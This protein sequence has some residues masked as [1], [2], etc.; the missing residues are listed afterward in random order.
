MMCII[1]FQKKLYY[2]LFPNSLSYFFPF[3]LPWEIIY[4]L[5]ELSVHIFSLQIKCPNIT[6]KYLNWRT[7]DVNFMNLFKYM[8][9]HSLKSS[10]YL[11]PNYKILHIPCHPKYKMAFH[12]LPTIKLGMNQIIS[13]A[14]RSSTV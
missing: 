14:H 3:S 2:I 12:Q 13:K 8:F 5:K 6:I 9:F 1:H 7:F 10:T 4:H 11:S